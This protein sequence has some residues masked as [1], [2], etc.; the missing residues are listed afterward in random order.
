MRTVQR[1]RPTGAL[2]QLRRSTAGLKHL[3]AVYLR[4]H[5]LAIQQEHL[6]KIAATMENGLRATKEQ[7]T[8][9]S[10]TIKQL[11]ELLPAKHVYG[12]ATPL[13]PQARGGKSHA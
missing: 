3:S 6:A 4:L 8:E 1:H 12:Q 10:K 7:A 11:S 13:S 5:C 2:D 9:V